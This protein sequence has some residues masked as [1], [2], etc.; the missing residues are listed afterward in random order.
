MPEGSR[1]PVL[2]RLGN[3]KFGIE[4][5]TSVRGTTALMAAN[6]LGVDNEFIRVMVS[7]GADTNRKDTRG[8]TAL[9]TFYRTY[10]AL[11]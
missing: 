5:S 10:Y 2:A 4:I 6:D 9:H 8:R 3:V 1:E 7:K 11:L